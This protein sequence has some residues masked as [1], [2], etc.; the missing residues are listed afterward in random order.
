M[1]IMERKDRLVEEIT[2]GTLMLMADPASGPWWG[3]VLA[4]EEGHGVTT[5][6]LPGKTITLGWHQTWVVAA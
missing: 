2:V 1:G 3:A 6:T 4:I 5:F